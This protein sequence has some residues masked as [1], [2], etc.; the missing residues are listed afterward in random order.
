MTANPILSE[1]RQTRDDLAEQSGY[2]LQRLFEYA[3]QRER[4]AA[5]KGTQFVSFSGADEAMGTCVLREE[6]PARET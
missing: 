5:A 6:P 3:R 2:D 1:I 4:E